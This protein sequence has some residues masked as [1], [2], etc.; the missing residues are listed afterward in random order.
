MD[1][2]ELTASFDLYTGN[3]EREMTAWVFGVES[4]YMPGG[5]EEQPRPHAESMKWAS[6]DGEGPLSLFPHDE[7]G[8]VWQEIGGGESKWI[9]EWHLSEVPTDEQWQALEAAI[10]SFRN[11]AKSFDPN[12]KQP[13]LL[14]REDSLRV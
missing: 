8:L 5:W 10:R 14:G 13:E 1:Y 9:I 6:D 11:P 2:Y 4:D 3:Y 12:P 7:Y